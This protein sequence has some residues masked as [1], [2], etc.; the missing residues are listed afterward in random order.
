LSSTATGS[1]FNNKTHPYSPPGDTCAACPFYKNKP[2]NALTKFFNTAP[3]KHCD[4][5]EVINGVIEKAGVATAQTG[6][7]PQPA[8]RIEAN[9][10]KYNELNPDQWKKLYFDDETG[11]FVAA[12]HA[13]IAQANKSKREM[14]NTKKKKPSAWCWLRTDTV[15]CISTI[16]A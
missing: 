13:R 5:C 1:L 15:C 10:Q 12:E 14:K 11:G 16:P 2:T 9:R 6:N 8:Q 3:L 7:D 4:K